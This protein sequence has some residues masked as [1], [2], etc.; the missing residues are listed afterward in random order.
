VL[1]T[2]GKLRWFER[3]MRETP[4][5]DSRPILTMKE[6]DCKHCLYYDEK[7]RKCTQEKCVVFDD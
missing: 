3:M 4:G 1:F 7:S 2:E 5:F 6:R